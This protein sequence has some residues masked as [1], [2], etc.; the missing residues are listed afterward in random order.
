VS[1][2]EQGADRAVCN[3]LYR[4]TQQADWKLRL[5]LAFAASEAMM[6]SVMTSLR[7]EDALTR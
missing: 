7:N 5:V 6:E 3:S 4:F 2:I 1:S